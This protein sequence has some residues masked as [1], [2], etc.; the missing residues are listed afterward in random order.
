ML[1][2]DKA[3]IKNKTGCVDEIPCYN[4][5]KVYI[6]ETRG[7]FGTRKKEHQDEVERM[8]TQKFTWAT[9]KDLESK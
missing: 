8:S 7:L 9:R 1:A 5:K 3:D 2:K 6:G 4:C